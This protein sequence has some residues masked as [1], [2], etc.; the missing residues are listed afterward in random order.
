MYVRFC[1]PSFGL[2]YFVGGHFWCD[3]GGVHDE[4]VVPAA[5]AEGPRINVEAVGKVSK[6]GLVDSESHG[7]LSF[8]LSFVHAD[9]DFDLRIFVAIAG[10]PQHVDF[11]LRWL[12]RLVHLKAD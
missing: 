12:N 7:C 11:S 4:A 6:A 2:R 9:D 10:K 1:E 3:G 8:G 5:L